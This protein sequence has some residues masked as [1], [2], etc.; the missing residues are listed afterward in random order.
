MTSE[1]RTTGGTAG[2]HAAITQVEIGRN[3]EGV[4]IQALL[5][6]LRRNQVV[7][8][9]IVLIAAQLA[10]KAQILSH[11]YFT[12]DDFYNLDVAVRSQLQPPHLALRPL[13]L[14]PRGGFDRL[15]QLQSVSGLQHRQ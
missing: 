10:W 15:Q 1:H 7:L 2:R 8:G 12:Q 9:G 11:L 6:W 14:R 4:D 5:A 3:D 13:R